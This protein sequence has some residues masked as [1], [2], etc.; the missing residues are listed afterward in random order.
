MASR[1][2]TPSRCGFASTCPSSGT[3]QRVVLRKRPPA[4]QARS[5]LG[6][7][8]IR[9]A[10]EVGRGMPSTLTIKVSRDSRQWITVFD[11]PTDDRPDKLD[12]EF[13]FP[14]QAAK[15]IWIIAGNLPLV[16]NILYAFSLAEVEVY[17]TSGRNVALATCGTGV[18][19]NS[20][21][22]SPGLELASQRWYWPLHYD[23]GFKWRGS[24]ITTTRSTGIGWKNRREC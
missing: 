20:T 3:I 16:E 6:W 12:Y 10:V 7:V 19:V 4:K 15:Q 14:A 22:H 11:G 9:D 21:H 18:T 1:G 2:P 13:R 23:A 24:A 17:D 8:P 5:T